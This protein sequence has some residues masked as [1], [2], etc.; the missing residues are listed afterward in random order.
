V[1]LK[2]YIVRRVELA[3]PITVN[4]RKNAGYTFLWEGF[5]TLPQEGISLN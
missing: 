1:L 2:V 4:L 5:L 3:T